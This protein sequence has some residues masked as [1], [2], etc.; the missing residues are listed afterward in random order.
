MND[1]KVTVN[2]VLRDYSNGLSATLVRGTDFHVYYKNGGDT[3]NVLTVVNRDDNPKL[4]NQVYNAEAKIFR[5][6]IINNKENCDGLN[7]NFRVVP[8]YDRPISSVVPTTF[9]RYAKA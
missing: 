7:I 1:Y 3:V 5:N 6:Y 2:N 9:K 4:L 8:K